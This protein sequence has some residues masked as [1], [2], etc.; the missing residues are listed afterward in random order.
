LCLVSDV[1]HF[2]DVIKNFKSIE[3]AKEQ[4]S[5]PKEPQAPEEEPKDSTGG[6]RAT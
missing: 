5:L 6:R 2:L 4:A 1:T 3:Q